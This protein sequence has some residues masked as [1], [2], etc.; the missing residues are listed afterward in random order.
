MI[1]SGN[2]GGKRM[3]NDPAIKKIVNPPSR[4]PDAVVTEKTS[5]DQV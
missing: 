3:S 5:I 1:G 4:A 2:F